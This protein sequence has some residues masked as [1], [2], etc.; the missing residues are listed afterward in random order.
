MP[1]PCY[2]FMYRRLCMT[3]PLQMILTREESGLDCKRKHRRYSS[4]SSPYSERSDYRYIQVGHS[5]LGL[6]G[7]YYPLFSSRIY[8]QTPRYRHPLNMD[9]SFLRTVF[10][11]PGES[12]Y[13]FSKFNPLNTD[14]P[15]IRSFSIAHSVFALTPGF[16]L[17]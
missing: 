8:S 9:T 3:R 10:F 17:I 2:S 11:V 16:D 13:I 14:T 15:L 1:S 7:F 12:L 5:L 6:I 4:R